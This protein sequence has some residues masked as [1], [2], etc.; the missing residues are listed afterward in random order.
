MGPSLEFPNNRFG[1]CRLGWASP[2]LASR[3]GA[4]AEKA[5]GAST[6]SQKAGLLVERGAYRAEDIQPSWSR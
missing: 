6:A 3:S 4:P 2:Q 5:Q 1:C